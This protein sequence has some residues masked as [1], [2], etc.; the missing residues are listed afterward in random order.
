MSTIR[1]D[2]GALASPRHVGNA[3]I[4]EGYVARTGAHEY[5]ERNTVEHRD[6]AELARIVDRL[7]GTPVTLG[8]PGGLVSA[9]TRIVGRVE[10][11]W[12]DGEYAAAAIRITDA[13][14]INAIG[15][16]TKELSLGYVVDLDDGGNQTNT[17]VDHLALVDIARCGS[18]CALRTDEG[19]TNMNRQTLLKSLAA[20]GL[21]GD[22]RTGNGMR[23]DSRDDAYLEARLRIA[24]E[25]RGERDVRA[26]AACGCSGSHDEEHE[27]RNDASLEESKRARADMIARHAGAREAN[28]KHYGKESAAR[29]DASPVN[30]NPADIGASVTAES[31]RTDGGSSDSLGD[32]KKAREDMLKRNAGAREANLRKYGKGA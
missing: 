26:D 7:T 28:L 9:R 2:R 27:V 20:V 30:F 25:E 19:E 13:D 22:H 23:L 6:A 14:A 21:T 15:D 31:S 18:A 29:A 32:A 17:E 24:L 3:I 5:P 12:L 10:R 4:F 8:H 16:G 1:Q 11:A